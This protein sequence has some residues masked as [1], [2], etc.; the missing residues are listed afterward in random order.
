MHPRARVPSRCNYPEN[1]TVE[2]IPIKAAL[3]G[4]YRVAFIL[5]LETG[6]GAELAGAG[7]FP[8]GSVADTA[9]LG[10]T[11]MDFVVRMQDSPWIKVF[12]VD[13]FAP[14]ALCP[15]MDPYFPFG[16]EHFADPGFPGCRKKKIG[17]PHSPA[18][19]LWRIAARYAAATQS[20]SISK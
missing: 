18:L 1:W 4:R 10:I 7:P 2:P 16:H 13:D 14:Q 11:E 20:N 3:I 19:S 12:P 8:N 9:A 15:R 5:V 6:E 17:H